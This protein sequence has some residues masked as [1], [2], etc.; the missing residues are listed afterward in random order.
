MT[1]EGIAVGVVPGCSSL[2][3]PFCCAIVG[4]D[5]IIRGRC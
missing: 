2:G 3:W 5:A 4:V 1:A